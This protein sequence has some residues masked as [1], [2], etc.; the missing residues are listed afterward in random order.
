MNHNP[1]VGWSANP[2]DRA[3]RRLLPLAFYIYL[4]DSGLGPRVVRMAGPTRICAALLPMLAAVSLIAPVS[5]LDV[6]ATAAALP[7]NE[8]P[9]LYTGDFADC[10]GGQSLFNVTKFDAAYYPDIEA[11]V[12]HLAGITNI[13]N[14]FL[15]S[16]CLLP[17]SPHR[18]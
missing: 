13:K 14:E 12:F 16:E 18:H 17:R 3:A 5:A 11:V 7:V 9:V 1:V 8:K 4:R 10:L 2:G 15:M 6:D